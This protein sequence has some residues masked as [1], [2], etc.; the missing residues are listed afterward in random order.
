MFTNSSEYIG[1][2]LTICLVF[3]FN[4]RKANLDPNKIKFLWSNAIKV[5]EVYKST[6]EKLIVSI[7]IIK[8]LS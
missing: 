4:M 8:L 6:T 5:Q 1:K 7:T 2:L 3:I